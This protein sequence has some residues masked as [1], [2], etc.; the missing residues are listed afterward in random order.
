M[1]KQILVLLIFTFLAFSHAQERK[2]IGSHTFTS[3][4][5]KSG[6][7]RL[8]IP[9][10]SFGG[11][12]IAIVLHSQNQPFSGH[13]MIFDYLS[14][15]SL[16]V[17]D[18]EKKVKK[19]IFSIGDLEAPPDFS[20]NAFDEFGKNPSSWKTKFYID[21]NKEKQLSNL[22]PKEINDASCSE[23]KIYFDCSQI[24]DDCY[25]FISTLYATHDG[26][27]SFKLGIYIEKENKE[28]EE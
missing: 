24:N 6:W 12:K 13:W 7:M 1:T 16:K 25:L 22:F 18:K 27:N 15:Y 9:S 4:S 2:Q 20:P 17:S 19:V 3:D 14:L 26:A 23:I 28:E 10:K 21:G 5:P 11:G 8:L